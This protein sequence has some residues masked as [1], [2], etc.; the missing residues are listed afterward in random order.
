PSE[1]R[2]DIGF[3]N[4]GRGG[5]QLDT[6]NT[7]AAVTAAVTALDATWTGTIWPRRE[8]PGAE[9][10]SYIAPRGLSVAGRAGLTLL[11]N[12][13]GTRST[14]AASVV[15]PA[16][17]RRPKRCI[18]ERRPSAN[19]RHCSTVSG[20]SLIQ[21]TCTPPPEYTSALGRGSCASVQNWK[22]ASR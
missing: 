9:A 17:A 19:G 10:K 15:R 14:R 5:P 13:P 20:L 7:G 16:S 3:G 6:S 11:L 4:S 12:V 1:S 21:Y 8:S 2:S 18:S 22:I